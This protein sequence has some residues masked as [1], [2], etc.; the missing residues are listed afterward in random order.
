MNNNMTKTH[1]DQSALT[2][3]LIE[4]ERK[5]WKKHIIAEWNRTIVELKRKSVKTVEN[6][7]KT[8]NEMQK[9]E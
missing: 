5:N 1:C 3:V 8:Q 9:D 2:K 6:R 7:L 4:N